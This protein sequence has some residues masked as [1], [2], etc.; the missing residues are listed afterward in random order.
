VNDALYVLAGRDE[1]YVPYYDE[2]PEEVA[3]GKR[4]QG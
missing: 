2:Y 4:P 3:S 1:G